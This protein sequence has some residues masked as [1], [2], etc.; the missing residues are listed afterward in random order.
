M[1]PVLPA[2]QGR[3][4]QPMRA[5]AGGLMSGLSKMRFID[6]SGGRTREGVFAT[7]DNPTI[8]T[9]DQLHRPRCWRLS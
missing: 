7:Q 5:V 6:P 2:E 4:M 9:L 8:V 1:F 3:K